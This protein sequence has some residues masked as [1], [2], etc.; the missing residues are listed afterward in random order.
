[1]SPKKRLD[2]HYLVWQNTNMPKVSGDMLRGH[3]ETI[4]LAMFERGES[5]GFEIMQ[6]LNNEGRDAFHMKEG[7]LYPVLYR[8]EQRGWLRT[9]WE[10]ED[11]PR[12]GPRRRLYRLTPKGTRELAERREAWQEFVTIVSKIVEA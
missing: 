11:T 7:T 10:K 4:V 1:M 5:H 8:M 9:R 6:R 12:K 2:N 3:I